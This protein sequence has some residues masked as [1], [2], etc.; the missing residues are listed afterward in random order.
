MSSKYYHDDED[1][2]EDYDDNIIFQ[3]DD[4]LNLNFRQLI[5]QF[6]YD[7][8]LNK[9][10][11]PKYGAKIFYRNIFHYGIVKLH[12]IKTIFYNNSTEYPYNT[13]K[14][15]KDSNSDTITKMLFKIIMSVSK[16]T[17]IFFDVKCE[18]EDN[19]W[20]T[21]L[22]IYRPD[23][24]RLEHYD[25]NAVFNYSY[26][27][28]FETIIENLKLMNTGLIFIPSKELHGF[29]EF[30][31]EFAKTRSLNFI[32]TIHDDVTVGWCQLWSLFVYDIVNR[33]PDIP[34]KSLLNELFLYLKGTPEKKNKYYQSAMIALRIIHGFYIYLISRINSL[35]PEVNLSYSSLNS[36]DPLYV[37]SSR[38]LYMYIENEMEDRVKTSI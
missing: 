31:D 34:T 4:Y 14:L 35:H 26:V 28:I 1:Y 11:D 3:F 23:S 36:Y 12:D 30:D 37:Y 2:D 32:C 29:E 25:P 10:N 9:E 17:C 8:H 22:L 19:F 6:E 15:D 38:K 18:N 33:Y 21:T 27:K 24:N 7:A 5:S 20:H 13:I 16:T